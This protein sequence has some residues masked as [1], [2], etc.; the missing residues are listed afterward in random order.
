MKIYIL[1]LLAMLIMPSAY[2]LDVVYP[3]KN[4]VTISSPSTFFIGNSDTGKTLTINGEIVPVHKSG[5]FAYPVKL[6]IGVN[7]FVIQAGNEKQ[8]FKITNP[9]KKTVCP[10]EGEKPSADENYKQALTFVTVRDNVPLRSTPVDAGINRIAHFQEGIPLKIISEK[11]GFY[12]VELSPERFAWIA[13]GDV[14]SVSEDTPAKL[15]KR[16]SID[17]D[18]YFIFKIDFDK[19]IPYVI[20]GGYPFVVNFYNVE[21]RENNT[22]SFNF[23]LKQKL[24]GYSGKFEGNSFILKIRKFPEIN[25]EKP[26][27]KIKI[28][29]DA[30]HGGEE[31]GAIGCL[32]HREKDI[33]LAIA[34]NLASELKSRGADVFMTR[35]GDETVALYERVNLANQNDSMIFIS[36]HGNALPD[37]MDPVLN[38]GTS[39][40]YYYPQAKPLADKIMKEMTEQLF[41]NDD[42]VRKGSLA[43][44]RN[45]N[46]L[47]IL[48]EVAY[49]INPEDNSKLIDKDVQK[50]AGKAIADG[51]EEFLKN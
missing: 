26:L 48:I 17:D 37:S 25:E 29:I 41:F 5:G 46:A 28:A 20:E 35:S 34:K 10:L 2:A 39:I 8:V 50:Q 45:T 13:K 15:L 27:N 19:K 33:N 44:V 32:R 12:K 49:M 24:A 14:R 38:N 43:V 23:P 18:K 6:D 3:K 22:F 30:G 40:Y 42:K 9:P 11:G 51:V 16:S 47:S 7:E 36:I 31:S 4:E 21:G 1:T